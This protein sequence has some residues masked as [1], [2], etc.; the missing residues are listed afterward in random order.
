V[1]I[2]SLRIL[3]GLDLLLLVAG[4]WCAGSRYAGAISGSEAIP[5]SKMQNCFVFQ[6]DT[7]EGVYSESKR[8]PL[9]AIFWQAHRAGTS[10]SNSRNMVISIHGHS[11]APTREKKAVYALQPDYSL[12]QLPLTEREVDRLFSIVRSHEGDGPRLASDP[13]WQQKVHPKLQIIEPPQ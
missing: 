9:F 3:V 8:R 5:G 2:V 7:Y 4:C 11:I 13:A 12:Q 6:F 10:G 1:R